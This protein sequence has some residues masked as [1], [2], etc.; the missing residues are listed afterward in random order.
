MRRP[1]DAAS[2]SP[3]PVE[4]RISRTVLQGKAAALEFRY[5]I[6]AWGRNASMTLLAAE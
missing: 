3:L 5:D 1:V 6:V 2:S 4:Q